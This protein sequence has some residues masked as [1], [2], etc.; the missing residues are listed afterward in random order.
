MLHLSAAPALYI[1]DMK[2]F[3]LCMAVLFFVARSAAGQ[4]VI[5]SFGA[6]QQNAGVYLAFTVNAGNQCAD[7]EV[8][9]SADSVNFVSLYT[10]PG[11][12]G[13]AAFETQYSFTDQSPVANTKNFYRLK[14]GFSGFSNVVAV[15]FFAPGADGYLVIPSASGESAT[16]L[17]NNPNGA[18]H[19][20]ELFDLNGRLLHAVEAITAR[21]IELHPPAEQKRIYVFR[22]L[23]AN[24]TALSGKI[25]F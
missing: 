22:L 19:L 24:G 10:F 4:D 12:C 7:L 8:Q 6:Q 25:F 13:N 21:S 11:I 2:S 23:K 5:G 18:A 17:F 3:F 1:C 16:V 15:H 20:F 14:I 9:R